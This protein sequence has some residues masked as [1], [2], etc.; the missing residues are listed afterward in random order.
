[1]HR[2]ARIVGQPQ[3]VQVLHE[4]ARVVGQHVRLELL[5]RVHEREANLHDAAERCRHA[6]ATFETADG[7]LTHAR[8]AGDLLLRQSQELADAPRVG[9]EF[10]DPLA[11]RL[12]AGSTGRGALLALRHHASGPPVRVPN[13][14]SA[15][16][17]STGRIQW[18]RS[19]GESSRKLLTTRW[20]ASSPAGPMSRSG[21]ATTCSPAASAAATPTGASSIT[22]QSRGAAPSVSAA[23]RKMS[24]A[25]F[26]CRTRGSSPT[27]TASKRPNQSRCRVVFRS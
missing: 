20:A 10:G 27:T 6:P 8:C 13:P 7:A 3:D 12:L 16:T 2:A 14:N 25:G 1:M 15:P 22:T 4:P 24:G 18:T 26:P 21:T 19:T 5:Q 11:P 9:A 17:S 23:T